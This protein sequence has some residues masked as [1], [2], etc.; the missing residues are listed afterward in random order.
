MDPTVGS[1]H[2]LR[3]LR[4]EQATTA[5]QHQQGQH[6]A[7]VTADTAFVAH[8]SQQHQRVLR[9]PAADP[10]RTAQTAGQQQQGQHFAHATAVFVTE[11]HDQHQ[12]V[13][14]R[15]PATLT[16]QHGHQQQR[17]HVQLATAALGEQQEHQGVERAVAANR[18]AREGQQGDDLGDVG[19]GQQEVLRRFDA[20]Q[21]FRIHVVDVDHAAFGDAG[22]ESDATVGRQ[23][24]VVGHHVFH[25]NG[26]IEEG[27]QIDGQGVHVGQ[28]AILEHHER[29]VLLLDRHAAVHA[30]RERALIGFADFAEDLAQVETHT[31]PS[32]LNRSGF[33]S[34]KFRC[35]NRCRSGRNIASRGSDL[36]ATSIGHNRANPAN[37]PHLVVPTVQIQAGGLCNGVV[38]LPTTFLAR[39]PMDFPRGTHRGGCKHVHHIGDRVFASEEL[40]VFVIAAVLQYGPL[41]FVDGNVLH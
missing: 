7:Q 4:T 29:A 18:V 26:Q 32:F 25:V 34:H 13:D 41:I 3:R 2:R 30:D 31:S 11:Q 23:H 40:P 6:V 21:G 12:G 28:P 9:D 17:L 16:A 35:R 20:A 14:A 33:Q 36:L 22:H 1:T 39:P 8:Q 24:H 38:K 10:A 19:V 15:Q 37:V 27:I 5:A